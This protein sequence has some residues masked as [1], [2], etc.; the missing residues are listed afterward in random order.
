M[1][2]TFKG[3][4]GTPEKIRNLKSLHKSGEKVRELKN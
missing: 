4:P 2:Y 1:Y 3:T